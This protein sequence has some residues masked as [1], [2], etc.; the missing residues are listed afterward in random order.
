MSQPPAAAVLNP[1]LKS[2]HRLDSGISEV[3]IV[4]AFWT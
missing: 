1:Y 2:D 4:T 3:R